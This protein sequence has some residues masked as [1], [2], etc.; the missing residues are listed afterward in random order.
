LPEFATLDAVAKFPRGHP[1]RL[2]ETVLRLAS[3]SSERSRLAD[4]ARAHAQSHSFD[5]LAEECAALYVEMASEAGRSNRR[6]T[7]R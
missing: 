1:I 5:A 4:A 3:D 7:R 6:R 2:A